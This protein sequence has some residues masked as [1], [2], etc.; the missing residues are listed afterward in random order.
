LA[1]GIVDDAQLRKAD[2]LFEKEL[3]CNAL[4]L[5]LRAECAGQ[6][7]FYSNLAAGKL[8]LDLKKIVGNLGGKW[9]DE[10]QNHDRLLAMI[11]RSHAYSLRYLTEAVKSACQ[12]PLKEKKGFVVLDYE[13]KQ[14]KGENR[15]PT[16]S[17][18]LTPFLGH[19]LGNLRRKTNIECMRAALAAERFRLSKNRWPADFQE[20]IDAGVLKQTPIDY[21]WNKPIQLRHA[22]DG[23]VVYSSGGGEYEGDALDRLD[24]PFDERRLPPEFRLWSPENRRRPAPVPKPPDD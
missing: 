11:Y 10:Y 9:K 8:D 3:T 6:H 17:S 4:E 16:L 18:V 7:L 5:G 1:Q 19:G 15:T 14:D 20:M 24:S 2:E 13:L 12:G 22:P 21:Y 23:L